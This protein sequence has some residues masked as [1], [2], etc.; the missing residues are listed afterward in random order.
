MTP[1]RP[2][3]I[4]AHD[5]VIDSFQAT[6]DFAKLHQ[7]AP[8]AEKGLRIAPKY[9]D[10]ASSLI[11]HAGLPNLERVIATGSTSRFMLFS[12]HSDNEDSPGPR[13][14]GI[15]TKANTNATT[16]SNLVR[17]VL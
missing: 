16:I 13:M 8:Q 11:S 14:F 6:L 3:H 4:D 15:T 1:L 9:I 10:T 5:D 2:N 17:E 7:S 12:M